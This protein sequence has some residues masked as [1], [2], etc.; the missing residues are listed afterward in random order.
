MSANAGG[1]VDGGDDGGGERE[2]SG[3]EGPPADIVL[4]QR[5][6]TQARRRRGIRILRP[7]PPPRTLLFIVIDFLA[8]IPLAPNRTALYARRGRI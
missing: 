3:M 2:T 1:N 5:H 7:T 4:A 8:D 6:D